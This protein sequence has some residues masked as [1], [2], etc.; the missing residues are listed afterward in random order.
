MAQAGADAEPSAVGESEQTASQGAEPGVAGAS[1]VAAP[2]RT[3]I[4]GDAS[5]GPPVVQALNAAASMPAQLADQ[6]AGGADMPTHLTGQLASLPQDVLD[7]VQGLTA[8]PQQLSSSAKE[9]ARMP[10]NLL[11]QVENLARAPERIVGQMK[12]LANAPEQ[13]LGQ[14]RNLANAP[15][16]VL[17]QLGQRAS[18]MVAPTSPGISP[19]MTLA[20][21]VSGTSGMRAMFE[22]ALPGALDQASSAMDGFAA[23][24]TELAGAVTGQMGQALSQLGVAN[25]LGQ[26]AATVGE[27]SPGQLLDQVT[28]QIG[29]P[30]AEVVGQVEK[31]LDSLP[32]EAAEVTGLADAIRAPGSGQAGAQPGGQGPSTASSESSAQPATSEPRGETQT[33]AQTPADA[34][35][36]PAPASPSPSPQSS[37]PS[38]SSGAPIAASA[39][40]PAPSAP[41]PAATAAERPAARARASASSASSTPGASARANSSTANSPSVAP[42]ELPPP[43]VPDTVSAQLPPMPSAPDTSGMELAPVMQQPSIDLSGSA[44]SAPAPQVPQIDNE[45]GEPGILSAVENTAAQ[46]DEVRAQADSIQDVATQAREAVQGQSAAAGASGGRSTSTATKAGA[47][48][49]GPAPASPAATGPQSASS[50]HRANQ[51]AAAQ[52]APGGRSASSKPDAASVR[53]DNQAAAAR[54]ST[55]AAPARAGT[56]AAPDAS[57][58]PAVATD[59][60]L[61]APAATPMPEPAQVEVEPLP[62]QTPEQ[63]TSQPDGQVG[64]AAITSL[65]AAIPKAAQTISQDQASGSSALQAESATYSQVPEQDAQK[66]AQ[67][68]EPLPAMAESTYAQAAA[69]AGPVVADGGAR[70]AGAVAGAASQASAASA[71]QAAERSAA[72]ERANA[73]QPP[74]LPQVPEGHAQA[75]VDDAALDPGFFAPM[76]LDPTAV[77]AGVQALAAASA[78]LADG[79]EV[80]E[81][82]VPTELTEPPAAVERATQEMTAPAQEGAAAIADSVAAGAERIAQAQPPDVQLDVPASASGGGGVPSRDQAIADIESQAAAQAQAQAPTQSSAAADQMRNEYQPALD[83]AQADASA[84]VAAATAEAA[85]AQS[86]LESEPAPDVDAMVAPVRES[87]NAQAQAAAAEA[88][89]AADGEISSAQSTAAADKSQVQAERNAGVSEAQAAEQAGVAAAQAGFASAAAAAQTAAQAM[90]DAAGTE[91]AAKQAEAEATAQAESAQAEAENQAQQQQAEAENQGQQ[92]QAQAEHDAAVA[93]EQA[94]GQQRQ[95]E[96]QAKADADAAAKEAEGQ[97]QVSAAEA[98]AQTEYQGKLQEAQTAHDTRI[99]SGQ[100]DAAAEQSRAEGEAAAV[101]QQAAAE[102]SRGQNLLAR[103][104]AW[105]GG[106]VQSLLSKAQDILRAAQSVIQGI[107]EAARQAALEALNRLRQVAQSVLDAAKQKIQ[108]LIQQIA[109]AVRALIEAA[110]ELIR[111]VIQA[112]ADAINNLVQMLTDLINSLIEVLQQVLNALVQALIQA[113]ALINEDLAAKLEQAVSGYMD[114]LNQAIDH[115]Q[116][117]IDTASQNLQSQVQSVADQAK[118]KVTELEE[119]AKAKVTEVEQT[120]HEAVEEAHRRASE[121]VDRA[122]DAAEQAVNAAFDAAAA[123]VDAYFEAHIAALEMVKEGVQMATDAAIAAVNKAVELASMAMDAVVELIPDSVKEAFIDFWNSPWREAIIIGLA[124]VVAVALTVGTGGAGA[125]LSAALMAAVIGGGIGGLTYFGGELAARHSQIDLYESGKGIYIPGKGYMTVDPSTGEV[126]MPPGVTEKDAEALEWAQSNFKVG[127]NG[128]EPIGHQEIGNA[129]FDEGVEGARKGAIAAGASAL[130]GIAGGRLTTLLANTGKVGPFVQQFAS[131]VA[132]GMFDVAGGSIDKGIDTF[133]AALAANKDPMQ[134]LGEAVA[135][136]RDQFTDP[137]ALAAMLLTSTGGAAK[138]KIL[139][140]LGENA[141]LLNKLMFTAG[142]IGY[143]MTADVTTDLFTTYTTE[144]GVGVMSGKT[145]E[146][147]NAEAQKKAGE[148]LSVGN[149]VSKGINTTAGAVVPKTNRWDT[150]QNNSSSQ[151]GGSTSSSSSPDNG[152]PNSAPS[153]APDTSA[154]RPTTT[155]AASDAPAPTPT[156]SASPSSPAA[157][158]SSPDINR[159]LASPDSFT[160]LPADSGAGQRS[161]HSEWNIRNQGTIDQA[162]GNIQSGQ[163]NPGDRMPLDNRLSAGDL[164]AISN[165]TGGE[166]SQAFQPNPDG[167]GGQYILVAGGQDYFVQHPDLIQIAHVHPADAGNYQNP[168]ASV[169]YAHPSQSDVDILQTPSAL[170]IGGDGTATR[171]RANGDQSASSSQPAMG[172]APSAAQ[173]GIERVVPTPDQSN[174]ITTAD[175]QQFALTLPEGGTPAPLPAPGEPTIASEYPI[176]ARAPVND[177]P[178]DVAAFTPGVVIGEPGSDT[179]L[180]GGY[181]MGIANER[182]QSIDPVT[183][184]AVSE[185]ATRWNYGLAPQVTATSMGVDFDY[186][187]GGTPHELINRTID[188]PDGSQRREAEV[189]AEGGIEQGQLNTPWFD[190]GASIDT[191]NGTI[192]GVDGDGNGD[193]S[194]QNITGAD[195]HREIGNTYSF[196]AA[197][198]DYQQRAQQRLDGAAPERG[199]GVRGEFFDGGMVHAGVNQGQGEFSLGGQMGFQNVDV[200]IGNR[201]VSFDRASINRLRASDVAALSDVGGALNSVGAAL[202]FVEP[203]LPVP[204]VEASGN[205]EAGQIS[206][207]AMQLDNLRFRHGQDVSDPINFAL[208]AGVSWDQRMN[209]MSLELGRNTALQTDTISRAVTD[210]LANRRNPLEAPGTGAD[211]VPAEVRTVPMSEQRNAI[212]LGDGSDVAFTMPGDDGHFDPLTGGRRAVMAGDDAPRPLYGAAP[213]SDNATP[214][215]DSRDGTTGDTTGDTTLARTGSDGDRP[216]TTGDIPL[217]PGDN[218][219]AEQYIGMG[220]RHYGFES[221]KVWLPDGTERDAPLTYEERKWGIMKAIDDA[222]QFDISN[223]GRLKAQEFWQMAEHGANTLDTDFWSPDANYAFVDTIVNRVLTEGHTALLIHADVENGFYGPRSVTESEIRQFGEANIFPDGTQEDQFR[224]MQEDNQWP[225]PWFTPPGQ[226]PGRGP[227]K[228]FIDGRPVSDEEFKQQLIEGG[229]YEVVVMPGDD[230]YFPPMG[231]EVAEFPDPWEGQAR[232]PRARPRRFTEEEEDQS[233]ATSPGLRPPAPPANQPLLPP[234]D[235]DDFRES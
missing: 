195:F 71:Q 60:S 48:L 186:K 229:D 134:A 120:L 212:P 178:N 52:P 152:S 191:R 139:G 89:S 80:S 202:P 222:N 209:G 112:V 137:K 2:V 124:A 205:R 35:S 230:V 86:Q 8:L 14:V 136:G 122:F 58:M 165:A 51:A 22:Q 223:I 69:Q 161:A 25:P 231:G 70:A 105:A 128:I 42:V 109:A 84:H 10:E 110:A 37:A 34:A 44:Q 113:I 15:E 121:A 211:A 13:L 204:T 174:I 132:G 133:N 50:K 92:Q 30:L 199:V 140:E 213:S 104:L 43:T 181:N 168:D 196:N 7:R 217:L 234:G 142:D 173:P 214:R 96:I 119:Q 171:Y 192:V 117:D 130:G 221:N 206:L 33:A 194:G 9:L 38:G 179:Y 5:A 154:P 183:G 224:Y 12:N 227:G 56:E 148:T 78:S 232:T 68:I 46:L 93:A 53:A 63:V 169:G 228:I 32:E 185:N 20:A 141:P 220:V 177:R 182:T 197:T 3:P 72:I 64:A 39:P 40:A 157:P 166:V 16:Q 57:A 149:L 180:R 106:L 187:R 190:I 59:D 26:I 153:S 17:G 90:K 219:T 163:M 87:E 138:N 200:G 118:A 62:R 170:V 162:V 145:I 216:A 67:A 115:L 164:R 1:G 215:P 85:Q 82:E 172:A 101:R 47:T 103:G 77:P 100:S 61:V 156:P 189:N 21:S 94:K 88:Q 155:S 188:N 175:G 114:K 31:A 11:S 97:A 108:S 116:S 66:R 91:K 49:A 28:S 111:Q 147:A 123:V 19:G 102:R 203:A 218:S 158:G 167:K 55:A 210:N 233:A 29:G 150:N 65:G 107:L 201:G 75:I 18:G 207:T 24:A 176:R 6:Q 131:G 160:A 184:A 99:Q 79:R 83:Q 41:A 151:T 146:E 125:P 45:L 36:G 74:P 76:E 81:P 143:D 98:A 225:D 95:A 73:V 208:A 235:D 129:A 127:P 144:L 126:T 4:G 193:G 27:F 159:G 198:G 226:I 135:A 23:P 54:P